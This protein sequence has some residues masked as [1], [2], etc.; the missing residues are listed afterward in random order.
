MNSRLDTIQAA[1]LIEK[2]SVFPQELDNK[3]EL[4]KNYCQSLTPK[5]ITPQCP[6]GYSSSW[7][8][9]TLISKQRDEIITELKKFDI[10]A[11]VY[12]QK[13]MHQQT[14]FGCSINK[15]G[16]FP[17]AERLSKEVFSLPMHPYMNSKNHQLILS[18]LK[19]LY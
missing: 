8:Q 14:A 16:D 2:L 15:E 10:P 11:I 7:A 12:Y 17:N 9:Y 19:K 6:N 4:A 3:N 1:I 13:C 18:A 5:F